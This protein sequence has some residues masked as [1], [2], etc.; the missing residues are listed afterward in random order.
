[1]FSKSLSNKYKPKP[2][3]QGTQPNLQIIIKTF[4][5]KIARFLRFLIYTIFLRW[6]SHYFVRYNAF[7]IILFQTISLLN[8]SAVLSNIKST[9]CLNGAF[10]LFSLYLPSFLNNGETQE[11]NVRRTGKYLHNNCVIK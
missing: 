2:C 11:K 1:M 9:F 4:F 5:F 8:I 7:K 10:L 3:V 6:F